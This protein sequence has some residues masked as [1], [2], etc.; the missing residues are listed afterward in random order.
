[1][2][3]GLGES[4]I[5]SSVAC[6][7]DGLK[8]SE[9]VLNARGRKGQILIFIVIILILAFVVFGL[10]SAF[11]GGGRP[12]PSVLEAYWQVGG[13]RVTSTFVGAEVEAVVVIKPSEQYVGSVIVKVRK[14]ISWWFDKDY[15]VSTVPV[16][17]RGDVERQLTLEF[18][19]DEASGGSLRGYFIE[20][21][22]SAATASWSM[23]S[24]YPPRLQVIGQD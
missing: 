22:F 13:R 4:L 2:L 16:D 15:A 9:F 5:L 10:L 7:S 23:D 17:L 14:D 19:P 8:E 21:E 18:V 11:F 1:M 3:C 24:A 6:F 12:V 20:V